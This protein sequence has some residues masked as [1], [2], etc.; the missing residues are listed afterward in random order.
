MAPLTATSPT[1]TSL[2][3][4]R[5]VSLR[6][7]EP[8]DEEFLLRL[9]AETRADEMAVLP[10]APADKDA[11]VRMQFRAQQTHYETYS[12]SAD[13][14]V[15]EKDGASIGRLYL[16]RSADEVRIVD[17]SLLTEFRGSSIGTHLIREVLHDAAGA[18]KPVRLHVDR[19]N[20]AL[21][22]YSR[23]GFHR[24]ADEGL[25]YLMEWTPTVRL[26]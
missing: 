3:A 24:I 10:W 17:I 5:G 23:L 14:L 26:S 12:P 15:I 16:Q 11:F 13:F 19:F 6:C 22:L 2:E 20:R 9:Y 18:G 25:Y 8:G 21:A 1:R 4:L 7:V